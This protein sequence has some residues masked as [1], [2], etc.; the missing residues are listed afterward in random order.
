MSNSVDPELG[1]IHRLLKQIYKISEHA[2]LT[3][4]FLN[5]GED[6]REK[7]N[8]ILAHLN[9]KGYDL[10]L[11]FPPLPADASFERVG[12]AA[13]LLSA[14]ITDEDAE[15]AQSAPNIIIGNL[16]SFELKDLDKVIRENMPSFKS[17]PVTVNTDSPTE[18]SEAPTVKVTGATVNV[19]TDP[20]PMPDIFKS[21]V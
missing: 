3:G 2:S 21:T 1:R 15:K 14:Y 7:Y 8:L 13:K 6:A 11:M 10:E 9:K 19:T 18:E 17:S 5:G 4:A 12:V 20:I 16:G